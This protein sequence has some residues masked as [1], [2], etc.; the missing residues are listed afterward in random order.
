MAPWR[1]LDARR[2]TKNLLTDFARSRCR[3]LTKHA[4]A[5]GPIISAASKVIKPVTSLATKVTTKAPIVGKIG[6]GLREAGKGYLG[7]GKAKGLGGM[8]GRS[9]MHVDMAN[10][11]RYRRP[12]P[13]AVM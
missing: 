5:W 10:S 6:G 7:Y 3:G 8:F 2:R 9:A 4:F 1:L 12:S 11:F 13:Q